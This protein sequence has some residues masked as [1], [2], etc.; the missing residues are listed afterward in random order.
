[1]YKTMGAKLAFMFG[2]IL[3][4]IVAFW[5]LWYVDTD[6]PN[7]AT[8]LVLTIYF[9]SMFKANKRFTEAAKFFPA[10]WKAARGN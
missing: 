6:N 5:S 2:W 1:M 4:A 7:V 8:L 10:A 3:V 9:M